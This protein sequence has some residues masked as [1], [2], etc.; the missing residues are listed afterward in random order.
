VQALIDSGSIEPATIR[1][2]DLSFWLLTPFYCPDCGLNYCRND[3]DVHHGHDGSR[4]TTTGRCPVGHEHRIGED[5]AEPEPTRFIR[6]D[7][8][9]SFDCEDHV[10]ATAAQMAAS[11]PG[12]RNRHS[13]DRPTARY[14]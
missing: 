8:S 7:H 5:D 14:G 4:R 6:L 9:W 10:L 2:L 12:G 1:A 3:W 11:A 13:V